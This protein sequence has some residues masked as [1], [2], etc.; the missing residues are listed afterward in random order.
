[1]AIEAGELINPNEVT[2]F[3]NGSDGAFNETSGTTNL[4]QG[5]I[6][7]YTSFTLGADHTISAESTSTKP[8]IILVQGDCTINGT[9]NLSGKGATTSYGT[10]VG[11]VGGNAYWNGSQRVGGIAG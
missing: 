10:Y 5:Q 3:G 7:Q 6:Y 8:I 2:P 11:S 4:T 9:I 1:M